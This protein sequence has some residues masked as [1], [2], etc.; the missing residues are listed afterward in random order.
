MIAAVFGVVY[1]TFGFFLLV[2]AREFA[3]LYDKSS[4]PRPL[5]VATRLW[6]R[7][8]DVPATRVIGL[9]SMVFGA[10]FLIEALAL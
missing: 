4:W 9:V 2:G 7:N 6:P 10:L 1:L 3:T 8:W 5:K